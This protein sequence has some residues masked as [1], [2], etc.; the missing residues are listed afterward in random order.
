MMLLYQ[1]GAIFQTQISGQI[2][3]AVLT[4]LRKKVVFCSRAVVLFGKYD[5]PELLRN[6]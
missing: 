4:V 3:L 2:S 5:Q 6:I 1:C